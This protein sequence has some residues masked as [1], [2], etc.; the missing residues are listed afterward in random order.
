VPLSRRGTLYSF[1]MQRFKPPPPY[2]GPEPFQPYGVGMVELPEGL[3][4]TAVLEE[5]DPANLRVGME[6]ELV[7]ASFFEDA[8]GNEILGYKFK[9]VADGP[10]D[11]GVDQ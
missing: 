2:R 7:I 3:L 11:G 8:E 1:T 6:M 10:R 5:T 4:V 9:A